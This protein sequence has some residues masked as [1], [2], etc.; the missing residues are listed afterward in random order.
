MELGAI[1]IL[2][3]LAV[4]LYVILILTEMILSHYQNR[5]FYTVKDTVTNLYLMSLNMGLDFLLRVVSVGVLFFFF[6]FRLFQ[7][8]NP[9]LYWVVL[10]VAEDFM[11][12]A[13]HYVDHYS[14][15][16]WAV[17]VTH[18][19]SEYFN[20]TTG[21]R[22]SVFQPMYRFLYFIPLALCGFA[23]MDIALMYSATQI[24]GILVHT[25]YD[26]RLGVLEWVLVSPS[27]HRVHHASNV[28]Y[29]DKNMGMCLIIWDRLFG[30][31]QEESPAI[32]IKYGLTSPLEQRDPLNIVIHEW[33]KM[34]S[35]ASKK[36]LSLPQRLGYLFMPPGWSHDGSTHTSEELRKMHKS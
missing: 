13:L 16:F 30:T 6:Q 7:I 24:Y 3:K 27:H 17:H 19:S 28:E 22:S 2:L 25:S 10:F 36:G 14:R 8:E 5:S 1:G 23:P 20:L 9:Y 33:R 32:A 12:Y 35:D 4:P 34:F 26:I 18:H 29:L 15:F 11:F 21:F 31:Y